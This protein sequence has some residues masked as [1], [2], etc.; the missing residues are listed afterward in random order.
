MRFAWKAQASA[1]SP[2]LPHPSRNAD[3]SR[4]TELTVLAAVVAIT[5]VTFVRFGVDRLGVIVLSICLVCLGLLLADR[6]E[7]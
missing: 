6:G 2:T 7:G 5:V 3:M 1:Y 4:N